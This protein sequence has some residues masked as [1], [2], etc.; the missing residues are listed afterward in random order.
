MS[1]KQDSKR[2]SSQSWERGTKA[3]KIG[4]PRY[5]PIRVRCKGGYTRK[6]YKLR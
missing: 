1:W 5:K 2:R 4:N 3:R 6:V